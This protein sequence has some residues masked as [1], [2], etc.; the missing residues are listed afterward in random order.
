MDEEETFTVALITKLIIH[1]TATR[2][3]LKTIDTSS[4]MKGYVNE[5]DLNFNIDLVDEVIDYLNKLKI[6]NLKQIHNLELIDKFEYQE[7][8]EN[9]D[10]ANV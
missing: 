4:N 9:K 3:Y 8:M 10:E 2:V 6:N 7:D 1:T 5:S